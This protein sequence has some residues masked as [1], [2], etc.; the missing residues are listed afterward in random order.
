MV[1]ICNCSC[2]ITITWLCFYEYLQYLSSEGWDDYISEF[3]NV[4]DFAHVMT[5]GV[6][7][8]WLRI[9]RPDDSITTFYQFENKVK[10]WDDG[11]SRMYAIKCILTTTNITLCA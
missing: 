9:T 6:L 10:P 11:Y 4:N 7:Y 5:Y 2:M 1:I 8:F 3:W